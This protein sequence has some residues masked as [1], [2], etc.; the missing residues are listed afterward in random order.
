MIGD[1]CC[2]LAA[3]TL[4]SGIKLS[5]H[6]AHP[7]M[8]SLHDYNL[9]LAIMRTGINILVLSSSTSFCTYFPERI[10]VEPTEQICSLESKLFF[11]CMCSFRIPSRK[12]NIFEKPLQK[13]PNLYV[14][15]LVY[16]DCSISNI[17]SI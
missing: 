4:T 11:I 9:P 17:D 2:F 14:L 8:T 16:S 7:Q 15:K 6:W 10:L 12:S 1:K 13:I 3:I 5:K